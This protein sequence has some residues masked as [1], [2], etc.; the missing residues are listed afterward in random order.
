MRILRQ[1]P[2]RQT[3]APIRTAINGTAVCIILNFRI[4]LKC[5]GLG[6]TMVFKTGAR[7][8][9]TLS[10]PA[11]ATTH[12]NMNFQTNPQLGTPR[13][14]SKVFAVHCAPGTANLQHRKLCYSAAAS[15][16]P[17]SS[18]RRQSSFSSL[19]PRS[20]G[21]FILSARAFIRPKPRFSSFGSVPND[22]SP[23]GTDGNYCMQIVAAPMFS[24]TR[25]AAP[26]CVSMR[27]TAKG[28]AHVPRPARPPGR[29]C[30]PT[31]RLAQF[32][33]AHKRQTLNLVG[34]DL[35]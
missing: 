32:L 28:Q 25:W 22:A 17:R 34:T 16:V 7:A 1:P 35:C 20:H 12:F 24:R 29:D 9:S 26:I 8:K 21:H 6:S 18:F 15:S 11:T 23:E 13:L 30:G 3:N 14:Q 19:G 31:A 10:D 4:I 2:P 5:Q 27:V 33:Y